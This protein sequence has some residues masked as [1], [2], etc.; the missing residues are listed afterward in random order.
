M[1]DVLL[2]TTDRA[3]AVQALVVL[4]VALTA[5]VVVRRDR[6]LVMLVLGLAVIAFGVTGLR[7]L[8]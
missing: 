8:Y 7:A 1:E 3:V 5:G 6:E 2:P 4:V